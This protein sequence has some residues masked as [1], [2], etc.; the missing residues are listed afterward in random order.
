MEKDFREGENGEIICS[1]D[2]K[3]PIWA[4]Q[5]KDW[6]T[7]TSRPNPSCCFLQSY[8]NWSWNDFYIFFMIEKNQKNSFMICE[9]YVK[10]KHRCSQ[11]KFSW[12]R[13][14]PI[15]LCITCGL[16]CAYNS[17]A[18][19]LQ[20]RPYGPQSLKYLLSSSLQKKFVSLCS[21]T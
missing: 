5:L 7:I 3:T 15:H 16:C 18:E 10:C 6:V 11:V 8:R 20:G 21:K 12:N 9:N 17:R 14:T 19:Q 1:E 2:S 13:A 4:S